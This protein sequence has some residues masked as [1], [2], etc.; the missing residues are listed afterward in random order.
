MT[1][2]G[3]AI[4]WR[5]KRKVSKLSKHARFVIDGSTNDFLSSILETKGKPIQGCAAIRSEIL[6]EHWGGKW[7]KPLPF[8]IPSE[9]EALFVEHKDEQ[10]M[11]S[12]KEG[13][14]ISQKIT[15]KH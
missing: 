4:T 12:Y 3:S 9:D 5:S 11:Y 2:I 8:Q 13:K 15:K 1:S 7:K 10:Y 14:L 6:K